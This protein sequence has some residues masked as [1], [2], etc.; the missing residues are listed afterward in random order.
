[1]ESSTVIDNLL[2]CGRTERAELGLT[3][4]CNLKCG[5]CAS[6][7]PGYQ[8]ADFTFAHKMPELIQEFR[9]RNLEQ[10]GVSDHGE[11][12]MLPDWDRICG[13]LLEAGFQLEIVSNFA[14]VFRP[15]EARLLSRFRQI[16]ISCDAVDPALFKRLRG[17]ADF[18]N[19]LLNMANI[20]AAAQKEG[21]P[22]PQMTWC[23]TV[24]DQNLFHLEDLAHFG[25]AMGVGI[26]VFIN[27]IE[28][29]EIKDPPAGHIYHLEPDLLRR[30][31]DMFERVREIIT[32][33]GAVCYYEAGLLDS[34]RAKLAA[35]DQ[36]AAAEEDPSAFRFR[37]V[38]SA[39]GE[40]SR[41]RD[42]LDPWKYFI[43]RSSGDVAYCCKSLETIGSVLERPLGEIL[44]GPEIKRVR[45]GILTGNLVEECRKCVTAPWTSPEAVQ[46]K[47][48]AYLAAGAPGGAGL[49]MAGSGSGPA[50][51][52]AL[53]HL[54]R[55]VALRD[56]R[57][58]Y[59]ATNFWVRCL[60]KLGLV[61]IEPLE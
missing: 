54:E 25:L 18:R 33:R 47:V 38:Y 57:I 52:P 35:A 50:I 60:A 44:N 43:I 13:D 30:A 7:L 46:R 37:R 39:A 26:F 48:S 61:K 22:Q 32:T 45:R 1:M 10:L 58:N 42:C 34:V 21:R 9:S 20:R 40:G 2:D 6:N 59:F 41:T 24:S 19:L 17:G 14:R 53:S 55:K 23:C 27:L 29:P 36:G 3:T 51:K 12:T 11:T 15:A 8:A 4:R 56:Q 49:E 28:Y 16:S 5:Y 31:L